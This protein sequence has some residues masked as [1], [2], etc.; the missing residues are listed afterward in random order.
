MRPNVRAKRA[1]EAGR[2]GPVGENVPC[3]AG[4]AKVACR[5]GSALERGVRPH[6]VRRKCWLEP[7]WTGR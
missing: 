3:T 7:R 6:Y 4:R 5:S 2:L 1:V